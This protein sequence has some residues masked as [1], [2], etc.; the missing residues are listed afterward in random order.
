MSIWR[1]RRVV[2]SLGAG[3][4]H[5]RHLFE[6]VSFMVLLEKSLL[7][8]VEVYRDMISV[9]L[10]DVYQTLVSVDILTVILRQESFRDVM[11]QLHEGYNGELFFFTRSMSPVSM[12]RDFSLS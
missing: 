2:C 8:S 6:F 3:D 4:A 10:D 1:D 7:R 11:D 5:G 9:Q 12:T